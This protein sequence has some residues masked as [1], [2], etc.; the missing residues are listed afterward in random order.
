M[1]LE[2]YEIV[3]LIRCRARELAEWNIH[4]FPPGET[5]DAA[6]QI[7]ERIIELANALP[8]QPK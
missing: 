1:R 2:P 8:E 7:A 6:L 3:E 4:I 5:R